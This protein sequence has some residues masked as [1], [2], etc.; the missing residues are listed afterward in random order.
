MAQTWVALTASGELRQVA[1]L[2]GERR[3]EAMQ[4]LVDATPTLADAGRRL[5]E[6]EPPYALLH[7]DTRSDNLR[8]VRGGLR[9]FDWPHAGIGP[10]EYDLAAFAQTVTVDGGPQPEQV[11][12]WYAGR[13]SV[14]S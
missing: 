4:W 5:C 3:H 10:P 8:W 13:G 1:T 2:G 6:A 11:V 14:R 12:A 7:G 9:L